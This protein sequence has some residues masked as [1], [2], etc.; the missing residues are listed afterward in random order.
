ML[1]VTFLAEFYRENRLP[2][3]KQIYACTLNVQIDINDEK[4]KTTKNNLRGQVL[5]VSEHLCGQS[6]N[7]IGDAADSHSGN[8]GYGERG[9]LRN[10]IFEKY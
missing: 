6:G 7:E 5:P 2:L 8:L 3:I 9:F 1:Q 10:N 4:N